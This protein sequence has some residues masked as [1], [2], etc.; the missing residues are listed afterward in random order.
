MTATITQIYRYPVKSVGGET[1]QRAT[2]SALGIPGDRCWALRGEDGRIGI[3]KKSPIPQGM[4]ASF[5]QEPDGSVSSPTAVIELPDGQQVR[6]DDPSANRLLSDALGSTFRL[7]SLLPPDEAIA[8][9]PPPPGIDVEEYLREVFARTPDEPLPDV[10]S[11]PD[12]VNRYEAPPGTWFDAYPILIISE[13]A[14]AAFAQARPD[15]NFDVRRFRPN[16]VVST[17]DAGFPENA[18]AGR[19]GR[20]GSA[21]L[22]FEMTCPRCI[23]TTHGFNDLP[24][25]PGVMRAIV[26]NNDGNAGV[27]ASIVEPGEIKAGDTLELL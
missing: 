14:L 19:Q 3:G 5:P 2:L 7:Q 20:L 27:Y 26:Q 25:D 11:F 24:K 13:A 22:Q 8:R 10:R 12:F 9:Q 16:I 4:S 1:L 18:W 17:P 6:T 23:M 15:S 21:V